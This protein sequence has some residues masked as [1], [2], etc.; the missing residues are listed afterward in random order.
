MAVAEAGPAARAYQDI[1]GASPGRADD[2][3]YLDAHRAILALGE[4]RPLDET[5]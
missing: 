5:E 3:D 4:S 1:L 2:S